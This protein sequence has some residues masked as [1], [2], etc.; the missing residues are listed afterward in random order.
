MDD[1]GRMKELREEISARLKNVCSEMSECD[2]ANLVEGIARHAR[3][4]ETRLA[5][6][7]PSPSDS[8]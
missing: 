8:R 5:N 2:F 3:K 6:W 1:E 7:G 4:S